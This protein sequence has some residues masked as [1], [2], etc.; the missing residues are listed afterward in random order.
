MCVPHVTINKITSS[1][2]DFVGSD[3]PIDCL[4]NKTILEMFNEKHNMTMNEFI[5]F[6]N[7]TIDTKATEGG[8]RFSIFGN[9][10]LWDDNSYWVVDTIVEDDL[11]S[12]I[13]ELEIEHSKLIEIAIKIK[14]EIDKINE[15][16][17]LI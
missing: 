6:V 2:Y 12:K 7:T 3:G 17:K 15:V 11:E 13:H 10:P 4:T 16:I 5:T 1:H 14:L 8:F 9:V